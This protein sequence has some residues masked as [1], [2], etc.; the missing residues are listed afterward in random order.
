MITEND[1][2]IVLLLYNS[3]QWYFIDISKLGIKIQ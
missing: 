2:C 3:I 1:K